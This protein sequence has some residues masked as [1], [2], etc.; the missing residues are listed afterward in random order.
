MYSCGLGIDVVASERVVPVHPGRNNTG[1]PCPRSHRIT[2]LDR[3]SRDSTGNTEMSKALVGCRP[4]TWAEDHHE[5][6]WDRARGLDW[7]YE[8]AWRHLM[9]KV[10][11][12]TRPVVAGAIWL[13]LDILNELREFVTYVTSAQWY[14]KCEWASWGCKQIS[15]WGKWIEWVHAGRAQHPKGR[16]NNSKYD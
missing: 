10:A 6:W 12:S 4:F 13:T 3:H 11:E 1:H 5:R 8:H 16:E 9:V 15:R 2:V 7:M 14:S